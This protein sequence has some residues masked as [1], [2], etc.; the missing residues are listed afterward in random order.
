MAISGAAASPNMGYHSS[1]VLTF[2]LTLFNARLGWWLG[3]P[4]KAGGS[5]YRQESPFWALRPLFAE[6]LGQTDEDHP[7]VYASDGGHFENLGLY[8]MVRRRCRFIVVVDA[9]ADPKCEY[10]D[11]S[12]AIRKIRSDMGISI[13]VP[14]A[15]ERLIYPR[16]SD[17]A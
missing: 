16:S 7:Y 6:A 12:G 13:D 5:T 10:E 17:A 8:E 15:K 2:I 14:D 9:G 1:P 11:L 4:G 3:N